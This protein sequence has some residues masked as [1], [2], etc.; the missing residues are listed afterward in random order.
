MALAIRIHG[1]VAE[2]K[3]RDYAEVAHPVWSENRTVLKTHARR[4]TT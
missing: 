2:G 3:F 4:M 1:L